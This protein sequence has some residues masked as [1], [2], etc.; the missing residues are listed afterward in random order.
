MLVTVLLNP[1]IISHVV[2]SVSL[3]NSSL[4]DA[5]ARITVSASVNLSKSSRRLSG[6]L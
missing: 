4:Y 3:F 1:F 6:W 5:A 2:L